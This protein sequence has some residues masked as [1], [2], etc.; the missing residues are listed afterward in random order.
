MKAVSL[1][2]TNDV[3]RTLNAGDE[4]TLSGILY[5]ARDAAHKRIA[6]LI[7]EGK[8]IPFSLKGACVFYAGPTPPKKGATTCAIGP[9]TATRM[10]PFTPLLLEQGMVACIG[11]GKRAQYV[12]DALA[13]HGGVYFIAIGGIAAYLS[14]CIES[15]MPV[16]FH[17]LG[18][19]A[20]Y[21]L[22]VKDFPCI[23]GI[24]SRGN[25]VYDNVI[26]DN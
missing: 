2:L 22:H 4:V 1:P 25:D 14:K 6:E 16:A 26:I 11:K 9:T 3:L 12:R 21:E 17:D 7:S 20:I 24:D 5:T 8:D 18:A 10:D 15:I 19:E 13:E 23:V